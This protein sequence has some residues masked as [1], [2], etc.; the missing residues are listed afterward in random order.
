M[1]DAASATAYRCDMPARTP[2]PQGNTR[3]TGKEQFYTPPDVAEAV[4]SRV[5]ALVPGALGRPW[6]EPAG[7]TGAFVEAA[8]AAGVRDLVSIDIDPRHP[9]VAPGD[10]L[11]STLAVT[12]AVTVSNPPF[13][14]N[15]SL[16]VP[17][18]NASARYSEVI[19]FIVPRSWRKWSVTNRLDLSF[20]LLAD[21]NLSIDYVDASGQH[22]F[23]RNLLR[24]CLQVWAR[25]SQPRTRVRVQDRG[26]VSRSSPEDADV[27]LTIFGFG[28][29]TLLTEFP[30]RKVTTQLYLRLDHPR[31][32][33]ALRAVDYGRFSRN[34]AY[35]EAL[36]LHE[37]NYLLNE[38][39]FGDPGLLPA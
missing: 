27:A 36:S 13:G 33:E 6:L 8:L 7:G 4:V 18:F 37:I 24:T 14:R 17:F 29:G 38:Y 21:D 25:Q 16:S 10:F 9:M 11:Q 20:H 34:V 35:T 23:G 28:C 26:L 30:R 12:G 22:A 31:S 2:T 39:V 3:V 15:N 1:P 5:L 19:A 32:L